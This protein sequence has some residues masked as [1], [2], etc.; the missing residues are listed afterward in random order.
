MN[1]AKTIKKKELIVTAVV[2]ASTC[3]ETVITIR[4]RTSYR[5][6]QQWRRVDVS[7]KDESK[8]MRSK[9]T[10][11]S[12]RGIKKEEM[13]TSVTYVA[14]ILLFV[15]MERRN[16]TRGILGMRGTKK[17]LQ[18]QQRNGEN[19]TQGNNNTNKEKKKSN[20]NYVQ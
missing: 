13:N 2:A 10:S 12:Q 1:N 6:V 20:N 14:S 3:M 17:N 16:K 4:K 18:Q 9:T 15:A 8:E 11:A 19:N 5:Q 7:T